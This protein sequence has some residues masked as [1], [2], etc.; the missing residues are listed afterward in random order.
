M[1]IEVGRN[2]VADG[3]EPLHVVFAQS[4]DLAHAETQR[5]RSLPPPER[6]RV[7][8]GVR[9]RVRNMTPTRR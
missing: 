6:G 2:A 9:L 4:V 8:E 3:D 7:G 5:K 1:R